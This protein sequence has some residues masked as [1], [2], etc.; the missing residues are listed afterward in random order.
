[1]STSFSTDIRPL[2]RERDVASMN[3]LGLDLSSHGDVSG[4]ADAILARL[5]AGD[6]P[7]DGAWS[8]D[9]ISLFATWMSEGKQ[10]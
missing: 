1:M 10:P 9:Q 2:F 7:C 4:Q 3:R 5:H 6:M 8:S